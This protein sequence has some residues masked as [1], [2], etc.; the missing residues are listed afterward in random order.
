[1]NKILKIDWKEELKNAWE[2][3]AEIPD[4]ER[5]CAMDILINEIEREDE[6]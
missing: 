4:Q 5:E 6:E 2:K 1:M 3:L